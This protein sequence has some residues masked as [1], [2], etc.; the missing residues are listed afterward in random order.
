[1]FYS[2]IKG[3]KNNTFIVLLIKAIRDYIYGYLHYI[4][5]LK[6]FSYFVCDSF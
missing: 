4:K 2:V 6:T 5:C 1:M 3:S